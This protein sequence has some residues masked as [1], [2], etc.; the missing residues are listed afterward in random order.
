M[1]NELDEALCRDFPLLYRRRDSDLRETAMCWGFECGDGWEPIIREL[2]EKLEA[3]LQKMPEDERGTCCASQVKEK[4]GT[5]RFYM[6]CSTDEM[7]N[8]INYAEHRSAYVCEI[9]GKPAKNIDDRGW[10]IVRCPD[11]YS[12]LKK[13]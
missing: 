3:I 10:Y 2:S 11:C 8:L 9:C 4:Y 13:G 1:K 12:A 6:H 5:L 7:D